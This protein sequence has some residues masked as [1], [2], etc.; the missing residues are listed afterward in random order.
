MVEGR[1][2]KILKQK[3]LMEQPYIRDPSM[4]VEELVKGYISTLGENIQVAR[5]ERM[6]LGESSADEEASE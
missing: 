5:F 2:G 4:T 3:V 6:N 1:L